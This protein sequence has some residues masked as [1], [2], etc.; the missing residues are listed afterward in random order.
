MAKKLINLVCILL[1]TSFIAPS[2][3]AQTPDPPGQANKELAPHAPGEVLVKFQPWVN[4]AQA[5]QHLAALNLKV[6]RTIPALGVKL[7][8]L[9]PGLT[10]EEA[11]N[12]ISNRHGVEYVEPNY[13]LQI[14]ALQQEEITDQ[15]ALTKIQAPAAWATFSE[16]DKIPVVL[17]AV[18]TGIDPAHTDLA[19]NVWSNDGEIAENGLDDDGNGF[20][21]DTWGWDFVNNDSDPLDD[22]LH[23]TAVSSVMAG[24]LDGSGVAGVCPWCQVMAVKVMS[25]QGIGYL[26]VVANGITYAAD[27]GAKVINLSLAGTAGDQVLQDA[28]DYAWTQGAL[29]VAGAGNDGANAPM[30]P[31]GYDNAMAIAAT[32]ESDAHACFS[33]YAQDYISVAA[34]G[35]NILVALPGDE[36]G[37]GSGTSLSSPLVAGLGGL[38]LSQDTDRTNFDLR[39]IIESTAVDLSP[40]GF[41]ATF[42][43]GRIDALRAVSNVTSQETPPDGMFS[44]NGTA[45]GYAH[46]RKLVRDASGKLHVIWHTQD[47]ALYRIRYATSTN[48][49]AKWDLQPDVYSNELETYHS[50]LAVDAQNLYVAIPR[51]SAAGA[52]Y[53]IFFT[54]KPLLSGSWSQAEALMGS[55]YDAVRPDLFLDPTNGKLHLLASSLDNAPLLYYRSSSDQGG[56]W[57]EPVTEINPSFGT[58]SAGANTRYAT[59]HANG[60]NIYIAT[61]TMNQVWIFTDFF[62]HTVR[63]TD[64]GQTW[65]DQTQIASFQAMTSG[66]YGVS[67][68][69]VGDRL[70]MGY[71]LFT[72]IY[73]RRFDNGSW[74]DYEELE[75]GSGEDLFRWP[76]ITQAPDG[77]AWMLFEANGQ[78]YM[79]HYDGSTWAPKQAVG[80]GSYANF[81]QGTSGDRVEWISTQCNGAPFLLAYDA[82]QLGANNPPQVDDQ[83]VSTNEDTSLPITLTGSDPENDPLTFSITVQPAHGTVTG[84]PPAV[85]YQPD[86]DYFGPDSFTFVANDGSQN[87]NPGIISI[88]VDPVNDPPTAIDDSVSTEEDTPIGIILTGGDVDGDS[89]TYSVETNPLHGSLSETAPDLVYTPDA[90]YVGADSFTFITNDGT[91][92]SAPGTISIQ[93]TQAN[94][95]PSVDDQSLSTDEDIGLPITLT[96]SDPENDPLTYSITVQPNNGTL[97]GTAPNVT[98]QPNANYYGADSFTFVANDGSADSNPGIISITVDPVND[99]PTANDDNV[100]TA[101]DT[102]VGITL[103]GADVDGVISSY[104]VVTGPLHG[105][106]SETEPNLV[107]TPAE[108]YFGAD[109][110][111]FITNDGTLD[112]DPGKIS[113][114]ITTV[115]DPPIANGQSL[116]T[117]EDISLPITLTGSDPDDVTLTFSIATTPANG[118]LSGTLPFMS[119]QPNPDF[120]GSDSFTFVANDGQIDSSTG[121]ISITINPVNDAPTANIINDS[122][123]ENTTDTWIPDVNDVDG[124][125]L[126]CT[127]SAHPGGG[128]SASVVG[129]CSSGLYTPPPAYSGT[130]S[131][132]Y[133]V[134]DPDNDCA[135]ATVSYT[136]TS[137]SMHVGDLDAISI[138]APRNRW[139]AKVEITVH[140][141]YENPVANATVEGTWT[142]GISGSGSCTTDASGFCYIDKTN[143]KGNVL[144]PVYTITN[145]IHT[146]LN[147][148]PADNH[149]SEPDSDGTVIVVYKDAV[150]QNQPPQASFTYSCTGLSCDFNGTGSSDSDGSIVS[151]EWDF[152]DAITGSGVTTSHPYAREGTYIVEL[153]VTDDD[154]ATDTATQQVTVGSSVPQSMHV[155]DLIGDSELG[156]KG[157]W[158][159]FVNVTIHGSGDNVLEG[160]TVS[161]SWSTGREMSCTT[162]SSGYCSIT[163]SNLKTTL[164]SVTFTVINVSA[165]GWEYNANDNHETAI[166]INRPPLP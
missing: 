104:S 15:W 105:S 119:Y 12:R 109:S 17:A 51:R 161:G 76:T 114:Q 148:K 7:V 122:T 84:T 123:Q 40:P 56:T 33:N 149:D 113:I 165:S 162:S 97:T 43:Y 54:Q 41:D 126:T 29:V 120:N 158:D 3:L 98:Y 91:L 77:Q 133:Q 96:A 140:D 53:Q 127:I 99:P 83:S 37:I 25:D 11:L 6:K 159:A 20:I 16:P 75:L 141:A 8:K 9:P 79:R 32:G 19:A 2:A 42:G 60:D 55:T 13:I 93:V 101:E 89:F 69:G 4:S 52:P 59:I 137:S 95:P 62:L 156:R 124:D 23:G 30:Y 74:S 112:S 110:F 45:S 72:N 151:Y 138:A 64:G 82:L 147:Y 166:T 136:I 68:A 63:S 103:S 35:E 106:L 67:L 115:N 34:P 26:D 164:G 160:A 57:S 36:Y 139:N 116:S 117:D 22:N 107:Y 66:D 135:Q 150:P 44:T 10:V 27:N 18:D 80:T 125:D 152:G 94:D 142:E 87:S 31:A 155:A 38:L 49:G 90:D 21:D 144:S 153:T 92:N 73:F 85:T 39:S 1:I 46:A 132:T 102:P 48:N 70:Y 61:K 88:T 47:G 163:L 143:I 111:T 24:I 128:A 71:E 157:R 78:L 81:K 65:F 50:A 58:P 131:F 118:V 146:D 100:V 5:A 28:V 129:D 86:A 108:D 130:D 121:T 154:G 145:I 134:C 14:S